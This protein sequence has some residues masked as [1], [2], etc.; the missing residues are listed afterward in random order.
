[1]TLGV[2]IGYSLLAKKS[3]IPQPP[4]TTTQRYPIYLIAPCKLTT[5][6]RHA[7]TLIASDRFACVLVGVFAAFVWT[8]FPRVISSRSIARK[9]LGHALSLV[10][11]Y[12]N[13]MHST[14]GLWAS[15]APRNLAQQQRLNKA[16]DKL[17]S[18]QLITLDAIREHIRFSRFEP[19]M[20]HDFPGDL[21]R[22]ITDQLDSMISYM[23]LIIYATTFLSPSAQE[24]PFEVNSTW[25]QRLLQAY[26]SPAFT[27]HSNV[28][29]LSVLSMSVSENQPLPPGLTVSKPYHLARL[30]REIGPE[31]SEWEMVQAEGFSEFAVVEIG[32]GLLY[33]SLARLL[34][35]VEELV[36]VWDFGGAEK[37]A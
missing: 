32:F 7:S 22:D 9:K 15:G 17:F 34:E 18:R 14:V 13:C 35:R 12:Y 11:S 21:Y 3:S 23:N 31:T 6:K 5:Y 1:M 19:S 16:R 24:E 29:L 25:R 26:T 33:G 10:G 2:I 20:G 8:I 37:M 27:S 28:A 30:V 36:G 4:A